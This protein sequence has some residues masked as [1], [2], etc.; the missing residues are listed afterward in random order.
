MAADAVVLEP[1]RARRARR[2]PAAAALEP[3][4]AGVARGG[5]HEARP[6]RLLGG[7]GAGR[8]ARPGPASGHAR[9]VPRRRRRRGVLLEEPAQ[10]DAGVDRDRRG[11]P[12]PAD[13]G[14]RRS[15]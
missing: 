8:T 11:S 7:R 2:R 10:G 5:R 1:R 14:T 9:T 12:T 13:A 15:W 6:G 4:A 3:G